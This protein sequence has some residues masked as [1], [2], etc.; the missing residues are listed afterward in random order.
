MGDH[1]ASEKISLEYHR[2]IAF[3][4]VNDE[5][6]LA[7]AKER[8][9]RWLASKS[10]HQFYAESWNRILNKPLPQ[11]IEAMLDQGEAARAL[12]QVSPFAG[13]LRPRERWQIWRRTRTGQRND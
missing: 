5:T 6:V 12:R 13:A 2:A 7:A 3:R 8:V 11:I 4:L 9:A 10:V 1:R